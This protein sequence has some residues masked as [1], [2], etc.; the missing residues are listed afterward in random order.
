MI[1]QK[2]YRGGQRGRREHGPPT[3]QPRQ[4]SRLPTRSPVQQPAKHGHTAVPMAVERCVL[5]S[6]GHDSCGWV[7]IDL[8]PNHRIC[9]PSLTILVEFGD[10]QFIETSKP[11]LKFRSSTKTTLFTTVTCFS[12]QA[13]MF[14]L[15]MLIQS[16][17]SS[18]KRK[19]MTCQHC[20]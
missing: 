13:S 20:T 2:K 12:G 19:C 16:N 5:L 7:R 17:V 6:A 9:L 8:P 4:G 3:S 18:T 15:E 14:G 1:S 11:G 10:S